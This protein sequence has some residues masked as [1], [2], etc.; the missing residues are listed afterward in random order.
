MRIFGCQIPLYFSIIPHQRRTIVI[1]VDGHSQSVGAQ[2]PDKTLQEILRHRQALLRAQNQV[3][4]QT[5]HRDKGN[6]RGHPQEDLEVCDRPLSHLFLQIFD[7]AS[8]VDEDEEK[9]ADPEK[10]N[11]KG[12]VF[13][14]VTQSGNISRQLAQSANQK[15]HSFESTISAS[16]IKYSNLP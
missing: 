16:K 5:H 13:N 4:R 6:S 8:K 14:Q 11:Q 12:Q 7:P 2:R 9:K 15:I 1:P 10:Q 3:E